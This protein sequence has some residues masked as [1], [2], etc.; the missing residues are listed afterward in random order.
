MVYLLT[1]YQIWYN[2]RYDIRE[3]LWDKVKLVILYGQLVL[4]LY[5]QYKKTFFWDY[6]IDKYC[7]YYNIIVF[8]VLRNCSIVENLKFVC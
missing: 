2:Y 5:D 1:G 6:L 3:S 8:I 4:V 7:I